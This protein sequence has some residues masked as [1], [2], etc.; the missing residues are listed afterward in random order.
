MDTKTLLKKFC[1]YYYAGEY[2]L[3]YG[4]WK[5]IPKQSRYE[6]LPMGVNV[7]MLSFEGE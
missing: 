6:K 1:D 7:D 3:A 5:T 2:L 4:I